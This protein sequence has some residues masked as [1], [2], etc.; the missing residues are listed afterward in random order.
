MQSVLQEAS[1]CPLLLLDVQEHGQK[2]M[3]LLS[4][5]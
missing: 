4:A 1:V 5:M 3:M 2:E